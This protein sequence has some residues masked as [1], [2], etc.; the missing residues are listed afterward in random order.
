M[1]AKQAPKEKRLPLVIGHRGAS[2]VAPENTLVSFEKALDDGAD[3]LEF[4]VRLS[5]DGVPV[6]IHDSTLQR[7]ALRG[8]PVE[9]LT[10]RELGRID[11][12]SWFNRSYPAKTRDEFKGITIPTLL[13]TMATVGRRS[14]VLYVEMKCDRAAEYSKLAAAVV[15]A[16]RDSRLENI[17][18]AKCFVHDAILAVK[19]LA[20][21][22]RTAALF[23]R[24]IRRP[25]ISAR[26]ILSLAK[27]C[28][29]DEISLHYSLVRR[30]VVDAA[31]DR[32]FEVVVWTVDSPRWLT[33]AEEWGI[34]SIITND[35]A[36]MKSTL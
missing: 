27:L 11:V 24:S 32:E 33:R 18:V 20:P 12:G 9:E 31:L 19:R 26:R 10:A 7:T 15:A 16:V 13:E 28:H 35:P 17:V 34:R 36:R 22:I 3:G 5:K 23:E 8:E 4:D 14:K 1:N 25:V 29:A 30:S 2:A 6:V 21:E